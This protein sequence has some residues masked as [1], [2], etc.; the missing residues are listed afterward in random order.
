M[1]VTDSDAIRSYILGSRRGSLKQDTDT[2]AVWM[3][4]L[5]YFSLFAGAASLFTARFGY[6]ERGG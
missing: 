4:Q 1:K 6:A 2:A 5:G 3:A